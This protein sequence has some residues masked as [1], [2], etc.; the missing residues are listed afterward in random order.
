MS[1]PIRPQQNIVKKFPE[2]FL[3]WFFYFFFEKI[4]FCLLIAWASF[5]GMGKF[6]Y[7]HNE[8]EL[9]YTNEQNTAKKFRVIFLRK[10]LWGPIFAYALNWSL[11]SITPLLAEFEKTIVFIVI[12]LEN[13]KNFVIFTNSSNKF[14]EFLSFLGFSNIFLDFHVFFFIFLNFSRA[15]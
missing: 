6:Q 13:S 1:W 2:I 4:N 8:D 9:V 15:F 10:F 14:G 3:I 7:E 11:I 5:A 12:F